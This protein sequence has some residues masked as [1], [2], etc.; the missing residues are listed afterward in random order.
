MR[1]MSDLSIKN[2]PEDM[3]ERLRDRARRHHRS[4]QGELLT[5][6]EE[7]TAPEKLSLADLV[8]RVEQR[9]L[10]TGDEST[11]MVRDDRDAR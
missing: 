4:L 2:V 5:I 8:R 1:H 6:L 11:G 7:A 3:L 9:G 10:R